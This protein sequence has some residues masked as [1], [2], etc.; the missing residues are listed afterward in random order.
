MVQRVH[1]MDSSEDHGKNVVDFYDLSIPN[2][3]D[4]NLGGRATR[5]P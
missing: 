5:E 3:S 2:V 1:L 4:A